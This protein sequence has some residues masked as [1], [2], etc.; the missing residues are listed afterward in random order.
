MLWRPELNKIQKVLH[1][2]YNRDAS[3]TLQPALDQQAPKAPAAMHGEGED[4]LRM[5]HISY[6]LL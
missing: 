2:G 4:H 1:E 5:T 3:S 6:S